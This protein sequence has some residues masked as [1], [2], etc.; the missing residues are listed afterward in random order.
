MVKQATA[1]MESKDKTDPVAC[2]MSSSRSS[3]AAAAGA[4]AVCLT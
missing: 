1:S 2:K 3:T 4:Q